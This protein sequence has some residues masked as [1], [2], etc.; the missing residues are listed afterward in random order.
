[1]ERTPSLTIEG[2]PLLIRKS[3]K[4][5]PYYNNTF[6][7]IERNPLPYYR[8]KNLTMEGKPSLTIEG[9]PLLIRN[10]FK[11]IPY[12]RKNSLTIE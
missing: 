3:F 10:T 1:M 5:I 7:T 8:K 4:E 9:S 12:Y 2:H 11:G 6:F